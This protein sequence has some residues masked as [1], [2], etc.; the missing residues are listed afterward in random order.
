MH[1]IFIAVSGIYPYSCYGNLP[2]NF[3]NQYLKSDQKVYVYEFF[4]YAYYGSL[5][6]VEQLFPVSVCQVWVP[7][8][9][10]LGWEFC[11]VFWCLL[12]WFWFVK[13]KITSGIPL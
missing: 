10:A 8:R 7:F 13:H 3:G 5:T 9:A 1:E 4:I 11:P 6:G 12:S 2:R